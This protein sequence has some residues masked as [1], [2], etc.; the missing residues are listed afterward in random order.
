MAEV[1]LAILREAAR[2]A[3]RNAYVPYSQYPVGASVLTP[4]GSIVTGANVENSSYGLT[5]CAERSAVVQALSRGHREIVAVAVA[6][7]RGSSSPCGAC[8]QVL[9]EFARGT[10]PV[11]FQTGEGTWVVHSLSEL[12]PDSF[13]LHGEAPRTK[14]NG[15]S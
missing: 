3:L 10:T 13:S 9:A 1:D 11:T 15:P 5:L 8:R 12:L 4:D 6:A 7:L 14:S 2:T